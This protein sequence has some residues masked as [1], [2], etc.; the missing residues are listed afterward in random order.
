M[1]L[2]SQLTPFDNSHALLTADLTK[3]LE[4]KEYPLEARACLALG[5]KMNLPI[6]IADQRWANLGLTN[7]DVRLIQ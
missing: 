5:I 2:I 1:P 7:V 3:Q 4:G 6:Y